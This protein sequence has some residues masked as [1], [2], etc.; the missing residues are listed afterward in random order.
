MPALKRYEPFVGK[1]AEHSA[2]DYAYGAHLCGNILT[3]PV[4]RDATVLIRLKQQKPRQPSPEVAQAQIVGQIDQVTYATG[5]IPQD[6]KGNLAMFENNVSEV[7]LGNGQQR[8]CCCRDGTGGSGSL[9]KECRGEIDRFSGF[10]M[11]QGLLPSIPV[12][13]EY[14]RCR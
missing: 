4:V 3:R 1:R 13:L 12:C 11:N 6:R 7:L 8:C 2:D 14:P 10:D 5:H 9:L